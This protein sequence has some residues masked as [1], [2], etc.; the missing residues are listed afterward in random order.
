MKDIIRY[1]KNG[2]NKLIHYRVTETQA[3]EWCGSEFT[4]GKDYFDGFCE[5]DTQCVK[6][7]PKYQNYFTPDINNK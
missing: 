2:R 1:K 7:M 6:A 4:R 5:S 3:R